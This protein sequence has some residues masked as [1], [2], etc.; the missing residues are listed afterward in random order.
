MKYQYDLVLGLPHTNHNGLA[1][2]L[3]LAHAGHLQWTS[4]SRAIGVPLSKLRTLSGGEVYATFYFIDERFPESAPISTFDLDDELRFG[5]FLRAFKNIAVEGQIVFD[6]RSRIDSLLSA[7]GEGWP[8]DAAVAAH[9]TIRFGNI[10]IT[11]DAGNSALRVAP[12]ANADFSSL[13]PLP[14]AENP[15]QITRAAEHGGDLG[16]IG[17][18]TWLPIHPE[19][20]E[21]RHAI[22]VDRDTNGAGLVYFA[23]YVAF[24]ESAEREALL[25]AGFSTSHAVGRALLRRRLA[26]YGNAAVDDAVKTRVSLFRHRAD[27]HKIAARFAMHRES[28]GRLV[29]R[30][31]TV[32]VLP[33]D[34]VG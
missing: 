33:V 2:H 14:N 27:A 16:V 9:P 34:A 7:C 31:E 24:M 18:E 8:G 13:A 25:R 26:Y 23:N 19:S 10:F 21:I 5:V 11:P 20:I 28:D 15:Y 22:D 32:K 29:C 3:L 4:I 1:D 17:P 12:P 6:Q 30:S